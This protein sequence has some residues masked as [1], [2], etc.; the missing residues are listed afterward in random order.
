MKEFNIKLKHIL[1]TFLIITFGTVIGLGFLRWICIQF[2]ILNIKEEIWT[3]WLPIIFPWIPI[4]L[5]LR[6]KFRILTFKHD[7]DQGRFF[8]QIISWGIMT[9]ML[10]VSQNYLTTAIG[11]LVNLSNIEEIEIEEK[12]RYYRISDFDVAPYYAGSYTDF[13]ASGK[14]NEYLNFDIYFVTPI[15][16]DSTRRIEDLPKYWYGVKF[17]DQISNEISSQEKE[18]KYKIFHNLSI[19]RM[20]T[21]SFHSL[22]HFERKPTS[23]DRTNFFKAIESRIKQPA[24]DSFIVLEPILEPYESRNGNKF[25]WIIGS[26][27]IGI[28]VLLFSL[29]W[30]G[31]SSTEHKG[32]LQGKKPKQG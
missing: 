6:Q 32:Q 23:D 21:Y 18:R 19:Q 22:D 8:F 14:Y 12:A 24:D 13:R 9:A 7:N 30:P 2:S 5:W 20:K 3:L 26:F 10:F 1:P 28:S 17:K 4:I 31:Y 29:I 16:T 15:L 25:A 27:G 11:N